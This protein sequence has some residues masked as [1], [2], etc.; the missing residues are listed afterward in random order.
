MQQDYKKRM[1]FNIHHASSK[2]DGSRQSIQLYIINFIKFCHTLFHIIT[3]ASQ[4]QTFS[5]VCVGTYI[6]WTRSLI[7][8]FFHLNLISTSINLA[9]IL[10]Y[11]LVCKHRL[12]MTL[13][14]S[15][16]QIWISDQI[17]LPHLQRII[18]A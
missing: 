13:I 9:D 5:R 12:Q 4:P 6:I 18:C 11:H 17:F 15:F 16:A 14:N 1:H 10:V 8:T 2:E 3:I 7:W